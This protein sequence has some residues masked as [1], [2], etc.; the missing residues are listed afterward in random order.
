[1]NAR[2]EISYASLVIVAAGRSERYGGTCK[3]MELVHGRPVLAWS[4]MAAQEADSIRDVVVVAGAHSRAEIEHYLHSVEWAKPW[5][6]VE[7]GARRQDSVAA[8]V[9]AAPM[10]AE[11][12]LVHDG[13][14]P[15]ASVA[16]FN[17]CSEA[18]RIHG[19]CIAA[20]PVSD[21]LKAVRDQ[22]IAR[23]VPRDGL[24]AAQTPQGFRRDLILAA[25]IR[26]RDDHQE[27]TD[28]ASMLEHWG[29]P[30]S[31][32]PGSRSNLKVTV[33]EDLAMV[34]ALLSLRHAK[35]GGPTP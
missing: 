13:A 9:E 26:A 17:A 14:R 20:T 1:M 15:L 27:F 5:S 25:V 6:L 12:I 3:V 23:T 29:I 10:T 18:A 35:H 33:P 30:V 4:M 2:Q 32:V 28:E 7:G 34:D 21:T 8:G 16:L 19:A 11:V 31:I 22:V 24:W